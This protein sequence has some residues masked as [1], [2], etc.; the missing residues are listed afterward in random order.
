MVSL[1][2]K[3]AT[4]YKKL[5]ILKLG[6]AEGTVITVEMFI[7]SYTF[8]YWLKNYPFAGNEVGNVGNRNGAM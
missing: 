7:M 2:T 1:A 6:G 4:T 5:P 3:I 8:Q